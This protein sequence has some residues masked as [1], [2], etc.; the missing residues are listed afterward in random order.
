MA[1]GSNL[2][3]DP[4]LKL[5]MVPRWARLDTAWLLSLR[6]APSSVAFSAWS[7][8]LILVAS[9]RPGRDSPSRTARTQHERTGVCYQSAIWLVVVD[10][11]CALVF[12]YV[13]WLFCYHRTARCRSVSPTL[14]ALASTGLR[15]S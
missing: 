15:T 12:R 14:N 2:M 10:S 3:H 13:A 5:G 11:A 8:T 1:A 7:K 4:I 6:N 9:D